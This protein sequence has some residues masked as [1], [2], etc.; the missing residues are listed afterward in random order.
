MN[1]YMDTTKIDI[2]WVASVVNHMTYTKGV[3]MFDIASDKDEIGCVSNFVIRRSTSVDGSVFLSHNNKSLSGYIKTRGEFRMA[4]RVLNIKTKENIDLITGEIKPSAPEWLTVGSSYVAQLEC[5]VD[6]YGVSVLK[7]GSDK[8]GQC[9]WV[10][11]TSR[12]CNHTATLENFLEITKTYRQLVL[13]HK[14]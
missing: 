8:T 5:P 12:H 11:Y 3:V 1:S 14:E 6:S 9:I 10:Q 2:D 7:T 13:G 4:C